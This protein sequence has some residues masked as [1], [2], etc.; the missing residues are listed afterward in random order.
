MSSNNEFGKYLQKMRKR[1][2]PP[3]SQEDIGKLIGRDKM[4]ISLIENGKNDPPQGE[5]LNRIAEALNLNEKEKIKLFDY[6]AKP[7]GAIPLDILEY[8]NTHSE[9]WNAIRRAKAKNL[10]NTDWQKMIREGD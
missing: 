10:T 7:R 9:V 2:S 3:L 1:H 6:A 4:T 5:L 8:F